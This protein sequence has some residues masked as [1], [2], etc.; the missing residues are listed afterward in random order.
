MAL[1]DLPE[2]L[3]GVRELGV[4]VEPF[5]PQFGPVETEI[6]ISL[7]YWY[8]DDSVPYSEFEL[9]RKVQSFWYS[10]FSGFGDL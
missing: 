8:V 7:R 10:G 3:G 9:F 2:F 4:V 6:E 1:L 5:L